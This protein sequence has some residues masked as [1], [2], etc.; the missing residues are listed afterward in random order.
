MRQYDV[1]LTAILTNVSPDVDQ[2]IV[3]DCIRKC[4]QEQNVKVSKIDVYPL[5]NGGGIIRVYGEN[6]VVME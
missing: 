6:E 1:V 4:I 2:E 5:L 3:G